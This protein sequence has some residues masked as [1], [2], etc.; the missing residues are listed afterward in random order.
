MNLMGAKLK[1]ATIFAGIGIA[2]LASLLIMG[3]SSYFFGTSISFG[4]FGILIIFVFI[5]DIIQYL[6]SPY[7]IG[8]MYHLKEIS[9]GDFQYSSV[10]QSL[11]NVCRVNNISV[12]K[13]YIANVPFPN[14]FAYGNIISGKRM[15]VTAPILQ[16]LNKDELEAVMAHEI[17]HLK[18]HDVALL[19]AIGLIPTLIFYFGYS[20]LFSGGGRRSNGTAMLVAIALVAVSFLFNI[21][22]LGVNRIRES[23]ADYN[24]AITMENGPQNLQ[25]ALAKIVAT[26][27]RNTFFRRRK[28]RSNPSSSLGSMLMFSGENDGN[29]AQ[30]HM[31]LIEQW[32]RM[33]V[34]LSKRVFSDHPH[35][36]LR[37]QMLEKLK[38]NGFQ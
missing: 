2:L 12:P 27:S 11:E 19:M 4:L 37:I 35:P 17:G 16:I 5:M 31:N 13:L 15:A 6:I 8:Y 29:D 32:K 21:M 25:T 9:P 23:Y 10:Y 18:H 24:S 36:A 30:Y 20:L 33:K 3:V 28:S 34:P 38:N 22:I 26:S 14:A 1:I 7:L